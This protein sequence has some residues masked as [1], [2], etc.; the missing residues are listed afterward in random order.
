M[1]VTGATAA[2]FI[3]GS[4]A[5]PMIAGPFDNDYL[6]FIPTDKKLDPAWIRSLYDR[7]RKQ[8]Y[9]QGALP[10]IGMP[11]GGIGA[12]HVYLGGDGRLW[13]WEIFNKSYARGFLG[14]GAGGE[15]FVNPLEQI[16]PFEQG[17]EIRVR[18]QGN[19][20]V[21]SLD[22]E[23]FADIRFDGRYPM[24]WVRYR[25]PACPVEVQ[26]EAFSPFAPLDLE[27]SGYPAT[28]MR[29]TLTNRSDAPVEVDIAGWSDNPVG[30]Y[31]GRP[32]D[33]LR[34]NRVERG[35]GH[36][37][38]QCSAEQPPRTRKAEKRPDI[39]FEDFEQSTYDGWTVEGQA[40][41]S[42]P[43]AIEDIPGYQGDVKGEGA[44]VANSHASAPGDSVQ[45]KDGATGTLVSRTFTIERRYIRFR[46]GGGSHNPNADTHLLTG[47]GKAGGTGVELWV[48]GQPV[49]FETG[50][51]ANQMHITS[52]EV[53]HLQGKTARLKIVD[54]ESG[55]WGNVGVD[56]I[57]FT[58]ERP[59]AD[60]G[61]LEQRYDFGTLALALVGR[62]N[63][64]AAKSPRADIHATDNDEAAQS[65]GEPLLGSVNRTV[66]LPAG[67]HQ[68]V[69][70]VLAWHF[71]N[72]HLN[73]LG[74]V[75][76]F[77]TQRFED[78]AAVARHIALH[79]ERLYELTRRW[80]D[81][82]YDST[83]P[84]WLLDRTMANT[85]ILAT[86]T[87]YRFRNGRFYGWEGINC[88]QGT[89]AHVWHY[90]QAP[91]RLFPQI[92]RDIRNRVDFGL[93]FGKDGAIH[94]RGEFHDHHADDGQCGRILGVLREHQ[95]SKDDAF[96]R[97]L[98]PKVKTSIEFMMERDADRDG[99]LNGAQPNTLD[100]AWYGKISFTS[101]LYLAALK[102]GETMAL[103]M[104][105]SAFAE[106][107]RS[108]A[109]AGAR[110]ILQT[111]NGEYFY[112]IED[113]RHQD[114]IGIGPGCY[115][116]QIFGQ[117][118]A[119]W[120]D[121]GRLFDR[122]KQLSA[123]RS[124]WQYNFVP[125][126][127]PFR[128]HFKRGRWY[129]KAGDAGLIMC[130]WP[131]GGKN[132]NFAK[133]WQYGYFNEC[134]SGFEWQAAAHMIWEGH[135][136]PDLLQNGLAI[137]RAIHDRYDGRLRNPYNEIECSDH[138]ARAMASYGVFQ[139]VC[140][141]RYHGPMGRLGFSPRLTP[142]DFKAAFTAAEGWGTFT[143]V[144][145]QDSQ[146]NT[147]ALRWGR[148]RLQLLEFDIPA[149]MKC[150]AV[151]VSIGN[152]TVACSHRQWRENRVTIEFT[153]PV[154]IQADQ[155]LESV[156]QYQGSGAAQSSV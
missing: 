133:H 136:Q 57:V 89:C 130:S 66:K 3:L 44:R 72:L 118:W 137:S 101:S 16:H 150:E 77:Y 8:V 128:D 96:L 142:E 125:D 42:G 40:F 33:T 15:T 49:H 29:Y 58:D 95:M 36:T 59:Q 147:L 67:R 12:G 10:Y 86:N 90:A 38:L 146:R 113:P 19:P 7:G 74:N 108:I 115:I 11:V 46:I 53:S 138:Y 87:F 4:S 119:H 28:V 50:R 62:A 30:L 80:V 103:E 51:S 73:G 65:W 39:L 155:S 9:A 22:K 37:L 149:G 143:Q 48:E 152:E 18:G 135:D 153:E 64:A 61:P 69:T 131:R 92:E 54:R 88:C 109:E 97:E 20:Q 93:A 6:K 100:A 122:E 127:G 41:G 120:V 52:I 91:G 31:S 99:L 134:M 60:V 5:P 83:L 63:H 94:Y 21:R 2:G 154:K 24:G 75:S 112:Q 116:D 111:Y 23:G 32:E 114:K 68:T 85:S 55:G 84:Y 106:Q 79:A 126:V 139:A 102:A 151:K 121:L 148:L 78:A 56:E 110:N 124:L 14:K 107:C 132:P 129:A 27:N 104:G 81:T 71:P 141:Y 34:R 156:M 47:K 25:D 76:R 140:G 35:E 145:S 13:L 45:S 17:F 144:R 26:L 117:T 1:Q 105:D 43:V 98:W 82:W 70:F 123:L